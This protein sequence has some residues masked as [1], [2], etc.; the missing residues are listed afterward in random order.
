MDACPGRARPTH[1]HDDEPRAVSRP[2]AAAKKKAPPRREEP[3]LV[4]LVAQD[5]RRGG[6]FRSMRQEFRDLE[7][8]YLS[9]EQKD[10]LRRMGRGQRFIHRATWLF[11]N[12]LHKLTPVRRVLIVLA[13]LAAIFS[14]D[15]QLGDTRVQIILWPLA[16]IVLLIVIMLELKDKLV[17]R[18]EIEVA[19]KVQLSLLPQEHPELPGWTV[20]SH[21][22]PAND[23]GGDL[24]DYIETA[25][26]RLGIVL[27]DVAGKGMGAALLGAKLQAALRTIAPECA[28]LDRLGAQVNTLFCRG[29]LENR[30]ATLFYVEVEESSGR[31]RFLNAGHNPALLLGAGDST[32]ERLEASSTP[33]GMFPETSYAE[34]LRDLAPGDILLLYSDGLTEARSPSGEEFGEARLA[35]CLLRHRALDPEPLGRRLLADVATFLAGERPDDDQSIVVLK[36]VP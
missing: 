26:D 21:S 17:A 24:V 10:D 31:I 35:G 5:F 15:F 9:E 2:S 11:K 25:P 1:T 33:L 23:V 4:R 32:P 36:R 14:P 28:S 22:R 7:R 29:G 19:R 8:F 20:W 34:G 30:F 18:D 3:S 6:L 13:L 27:G 16:F 12:L